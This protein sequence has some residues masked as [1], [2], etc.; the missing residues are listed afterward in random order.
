MPWA[1]ASFKAPG[2]ARSA[3]SRARLHPR[4]GSTN[5]TDRS[6]AAVHD[7]RDAL[8]ALLAEAGCSPHDRHC[9]A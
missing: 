3:A 5:R 9:P 1:A 8:E 6:E 4:Y 2:T 7:P